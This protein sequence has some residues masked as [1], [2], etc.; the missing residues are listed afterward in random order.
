MDRKKVA[1]VAMGTKAVESQARP[2]QW[3][4]RRADIRNIEDL[5]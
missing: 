5:S 1:A 2:W 3:E 4:R